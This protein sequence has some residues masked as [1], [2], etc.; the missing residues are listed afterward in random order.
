MCLP[1]KRAEISAGPDEGHPCGTKGC[2][3]RRDEAHRARRVD[4][5]YVRID[6]DPGVKDGASGQSKGARGK[7][8]REIAL[9]ADPA[10]CELLENYRKK[11]YKARIRLLNALLA[12]PV[13][14][15]P[16]VSKELKITA[17]TLHDGRAGACWK[18][19]VRAPGEL[20]YL[21]RQEEQLGKTKRTAAGRGDGDLEKEWKGRTAPA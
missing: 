10:E 7:E 6:D 12:Q 1:R 3:D 16:V 2:G 21:M 20:R 5:S 19:A 8:T 11:N 15:G 17:D 18:S 14:P 13:L 4:A 9:L